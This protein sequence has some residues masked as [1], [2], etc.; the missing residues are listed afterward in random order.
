MPLTRK[1]G[2]MHLSWSANHVSSS[3]SELFKLHIYFENP[4]ADKVYA[5]I[6]PARKYQPDSGTLELLRGLLKAC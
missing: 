2:D 1:F 5:A 3:R 6:K 4:S